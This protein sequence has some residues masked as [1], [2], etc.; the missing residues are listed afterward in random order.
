M[1][2]CT[3]IVLNDE[4]DDFS[5]P[6]I[7]NYFTLPPSP[8]NFIR[9]YK[10][11]MSSMSPLIV[12]DKNRDVRLAAGSAGGSKITTATS[13]VRIGTFVSVITSAFNFMVYLEL[14]H[15]KM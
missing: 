10:R 4:M 15:T 3:G 14:L 1:S 12:L 6:S 8:A 2:P 5:S 9:P 7:I 13:L 11:P